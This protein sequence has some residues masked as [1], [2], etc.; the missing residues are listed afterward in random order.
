MGANQRLAERAVTLLLSMNLGIT[1][2]WHEMRAIKSK[3]RACQA[4][5]ILV[6]NQAL[7]VLRWVLFLSMTTFLVQVNVE[8]LITVRLL[9]KCFASEKLCWI[10]SAG[11]PL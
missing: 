1:I 7:S 3:S 9:P 2:N 8:D 11:T 5:K 6:F 10:P 4:L